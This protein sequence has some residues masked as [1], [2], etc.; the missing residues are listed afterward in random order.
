MSP[1][2]AASRRRMSDDQSVPGAGWTPP[3]HPPQPLQPIQP[4]GQQTPTD[5]LGGPSPASPHRGRRWGLVGGAAVA[6]VALAGA[7]AWAVTQ[8]L[9]AGAQ[10][11]TAA[12]ANTLAYV[13]LDLDPSGGQKIEALRTLRKF[14]AL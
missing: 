12:P 4:T 11:A 3:T 9:G 2:S 10:P 6:V 7:T 14:P 8:F 1:K 13:G 5:Y